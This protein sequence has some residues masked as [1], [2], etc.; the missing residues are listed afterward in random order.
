MYWLAEI[1]SSWV[2]NKH[3]GDGNALKGDI[4]ALNSHN[5]L[6]RAERLVAVVGVDELAVI[7]TKDA[8]L[9]V[10]LDQAQKVK[11]LVGG[12]TGRTELTDQREV[13][14]PWGSYDV[15]DAGSNYK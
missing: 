15:V 3:D 14:R 2:K 13:Y 11:E 12:L 10:P 7:E 1:S 6:V 9:V 5:C 4:I 8:V